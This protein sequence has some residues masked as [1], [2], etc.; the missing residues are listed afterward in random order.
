MLD[1]LYKQESIY[2][3]RSQ[4]KTGRRSRGPW[5]ELEQ[6]AVKSAKILVEFGCAQYEETKRALGKRGTLVRRARLVNLGREVLE[7]GP[8]KGV[9]K[10]PGYY[11][12]GLV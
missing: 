4:L 6:H 11:T 9:V 7:K 10:T 1:F 5:I 2:G 3:K 8:P 12:W